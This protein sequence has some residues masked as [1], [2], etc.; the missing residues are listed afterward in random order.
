MASNI[1]TRPDLP[2]A[3]SNRIAEVQAQIRTKQFKLTDMPGYVRGEPPSV[4]TWH[5]IDAREIYPKIYGRDFGAN[6]I[7]RLREV[8]LIEIT[9]H[10]RFVA[11]DQDPAYFPTMGLSH[12][13]L[14]IARMRDQSL[15]YEAALEAAGVIV[16]RV[17]FPDPP[18]G[19]FGPQRG[20]WAANELLIVRGGS[21]IEKIAVSP[22]GFGR[23]EYLAYWAWTRLGVPPVA[24]ITGTGV[25]EAGPCLWLA[26]DV[27]VTARGIA[28]NDTGLAQLI[29]VVE[30]SCLADKMTTLTIECAGNRYFHPQSGISH[31]PDMVIGPLDRRK[32]IAYLPGIDFR[33]WRWLK[34]RGFEIVEVDTDEQAL[35]GPANVTL[36]EPGRVLMMAEAPKAVAA[37]RKAGVDVTTVPYA[38]FMRIGGGLHCST[39]RIWREPGP[40][41]D[42]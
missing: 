35:Y 41:L 28:Y 14:D 9:T 8:A 42:G 20:T 22:L 40:F 13:E 29:P 1:P 32:V 16:H 7:G 17:A 11:Y 27:F 34:E 23:A 33:N 12:G 26:E 25:A 3:W 10:E 30:R 38:E 37:V 39:M 15:A 36:I 21:I 31:H 24:T 5:N 6:G 19:P 2:P 4:D 18:V